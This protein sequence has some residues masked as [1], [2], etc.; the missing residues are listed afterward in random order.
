MFKAYD[1]ENAAA[2]A[3]NSSDDENEDNIPLARLFSTNNV[4]F[5]EYVSTDDLV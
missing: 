5:D 1:N 3:G 4:T 2:A